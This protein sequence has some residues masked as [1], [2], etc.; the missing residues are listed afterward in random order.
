MS[1]VCV[2]SAGLRLGSKSITKKYLFIIFIAKAWNVQID[3][4]YIFFS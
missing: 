3:V 4:L 2:S 1:F